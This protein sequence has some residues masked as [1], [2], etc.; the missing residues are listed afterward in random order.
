[1]KRII[2]ENFEK[3]SKN[4]ETNTCTNHDTKFDKTNETKSTLSG[5]SVRESNQIGHRFDKIKIK[6]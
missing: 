6:I 5:M 1:M 2:C 3:T 4:Y